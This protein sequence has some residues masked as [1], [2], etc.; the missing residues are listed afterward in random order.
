MTAPRT[1]KLV[2]LFADISGSTALYDK[3]GDKLARQLV[4]DCL[5]ILIRQAAAYQG[6]LIKTIGDEILCTFPTPAA[7]LEAA[8]AMQSAVENSPPNT[9]HPMHI[10]IGF[11]YGDVICEAGDVF[12]D[13]VNIAARVAAITRARQIITT[14]AATDALSTGLRRKVRQTRRAEFRGKQEAL[15]IFLV[16]WEEDDDVMATRIGLPAYRKPNESRIEILLRHHQQVVTVN[17]QRK[18]VVLG[19]SDE[20]DIVVRTGLASRQ[21]ARIELSFG[22][23]MLVDHSVNGTYI[24]LGDGQVVHLAHEAIALHGAG[25]ISL[26]EAFSENPTE[27][28]EFIV[29]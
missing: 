2:V 8:C 17:E 16:G 9:P 10:R 26:G 5:D 21:H 29:Q 1:E 15:D 12:G 19:R 25:A 27:L 7:A 22:K 14:R 11:H 6:T 23:F 13:T 4:A 28:I 3:L 20:C 18:G 24:R